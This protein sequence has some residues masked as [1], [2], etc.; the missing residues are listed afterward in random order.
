[1]KVEVDVMGSPFLIVRT[2]YVDVEQ[3]L[4][5]NRGGKRRE[6]KREK[7]GSFKKAN[8]QSPNS[9]VV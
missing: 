1:M 9:L 7:T 5:N 3:H 4:K 6:K 2:V 8:Q